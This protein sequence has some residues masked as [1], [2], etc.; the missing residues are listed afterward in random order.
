AVR[1]PEVKF[2]VVSSDV[3]YPSGAMRDYEAKFWLPFMGTRKPVYAIPGN[4]DWYD[5]LEGFAATFLRPEAARA[6]LRARVEG[7]QRITSTADARIEELI[8]T[9][10]RLSEL[11]RVPAQQQAGPFFQLQTGK[12][13][14]FAV[15]TGVVR[16]TGPT[17]MAWL[18]AGLEAARGK[19]K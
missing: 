8:G 2:V 13:A 11:Y 3:I 16:G 7:D 14:L 5:A 17:Q 1:R 10:T 6:A 18:R 12:F 4:H 19:T 15:D 9:A